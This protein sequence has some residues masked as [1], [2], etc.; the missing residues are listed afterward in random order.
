MGTLTA[1]SRHQHRSGFQFANAL[2]DKVA[3]QPSKDGKVIRASAHNQTD[4]RAANQPGEYRFRHFCWQYVFN[5][6]SPPALAESPSLLNHYPDR[7]LPA[8]PTRQ[9]F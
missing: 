7:R 3:N 5:R 4:S 2:I 6:Q 8:G 1:T 9:P